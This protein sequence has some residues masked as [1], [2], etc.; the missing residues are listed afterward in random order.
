MHV[1]WCLLV[2][3]AA[4]DGAEQELLL[5]S[6]QGCI[7]CFGP[8]LHVSGLHCMYWACTEACNFMYWACIACIGLALH[9]LGLHCM[10]WAC[11]A[12]IAC[13]GPALHVLSLH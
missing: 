12:Y 5:L 9:A 7:A 3:R 10:Y 6:K 4:R 13:I 2:C 8:A 1:Y 11:I